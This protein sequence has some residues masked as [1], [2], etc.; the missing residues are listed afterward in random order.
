[1]TAFEIE[2]R[3]RAMAKKLRAQR[4]ED[5]TRRNQLKRSLRVLRR[6]RG[7]RSRPPVGFVPTTSALGLPVN[8]SVVEVAAGSAMAL[9]ASSVDAPSVKATTIAFGAVA[10]AAVVTIV[11]SLL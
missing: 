4:R 1:M 3:K 11:V 6:K 9:T 5:K 2:M 10:V 8:R 7:S